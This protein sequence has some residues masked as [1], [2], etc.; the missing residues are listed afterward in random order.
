[1]MELE[2][3]GA[4][5]AT[6]IAVRGIAG[7]VED[8]LNVFKRMREK[9]VASVTVHKITGLKTVDCGTR[10]VIYQGAVNIRIDNRTPNPLRVADVILEYRV[11]LKWKRLARVWQ[12]PTG[13]AVVIQPFDSVSRDYRVERDVDEYAARVAVRLR[14]DE[15]VDDPVVRIR[16]VVVD[17]VDRRH[18]GATSK[19][20]PDTWIYGEP[21]TEEDLDG[22]EDA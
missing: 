6:A 15:Q 21:A 8:V 22:C 18:P 3:I 9:V 1:M 13:T 2:I 20:E 4:I 12:P 17:S 5:S 16:P 14:K 10:N 19:F 7:V 11:G